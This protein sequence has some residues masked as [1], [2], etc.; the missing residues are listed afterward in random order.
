MNIST[1]LH[2]FLSPVYAMFRQ[3][4]IE[5]IYML[6]LPLILLSYSI[7][8]LVHWHLFDRTTPHRSWVVY[9]RS[10]G[11]DCGEFKHFLCLLIFARWPNPK[12]HCETD[13]PDQT[14]VVVGWPRPRLMSEEMLV[15]VNYPATRSCPF[16]FTSPLLCCKRGEPRQIRFWPKIGKKTK[17]TSE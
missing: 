3:I 13:Q 4:L 16:R 7:S 11:G 9:G 15:T 14:V 5:T 12:C 10:L 6:I 17:R 2:W 8:T 1:I